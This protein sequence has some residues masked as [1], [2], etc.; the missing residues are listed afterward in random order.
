[1]NTAYCDECGATMMVQHRDPGSNLCRCSCGNVHTGDTNKL[2]AGRWKHHQMVL[3]QIDDCQASL[4]LG[5][6][7]EG[8]QEELERALI[9]LERFRQEELAWLHFCRKAYPTK[10]AQA[11]ITPFGWKVWRRV[12]DEEGNPIALPV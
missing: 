3:R 11:K 7:Q 12:H 9:E 6:D 10:S 4:K 5:L 1:M 2:K 8:W